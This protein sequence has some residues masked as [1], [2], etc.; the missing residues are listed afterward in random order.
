MTILKKIINNT[1]KFIILVLILSFV[2]TPLALAEDNKTTTKKWDASYFPA[3]EGEVQGEALQGV[4]Q[5][6][7]NGQKVALDKN[8]NFK[9][10]VKLKKDQR[11]LII[12]TQYKGVVFVKKYLIVRHPGVKKPFKV[13]LA[14]RDYQNLVKKVIP[15]KKKMQHLEKSTKKLKSQPKMKENWAGFELVAE[16]EPG[17]LLVIEKQ[18][19]KYFGYIYSVKDMVWVSIQEISYQEF[20]DLLDKGLIP[21]S[22]ARKSK[23]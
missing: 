13:K 21:S 15:S 12:K 17:R 19:Y 20:K 7:V 4:E 9:A 11:Y 1:F 2:I 10:Y 5:V 14:K 6:E 18:G 23:L 22:F 16:L 3:I 8:L